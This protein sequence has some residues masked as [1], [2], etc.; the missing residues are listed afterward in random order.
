[1]GRK[2]TVVLLAV[3]AVAGLASLALGLLEPARVTPWAIAFAM[4]C[5]VLAQLMR[6]RELRKRDG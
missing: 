3:A 2:G 1:M 6:L 5:L 4:S